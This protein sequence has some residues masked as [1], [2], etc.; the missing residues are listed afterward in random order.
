MALVKW[1][2]HNPGVLGLSHSESSGF[3]V[4]M[5]LGK[6]LQSSNLILAKPRKDMNN[7]SCCCYD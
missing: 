6:A 4:G 7:A 3:F 2:T 5:S 1:L